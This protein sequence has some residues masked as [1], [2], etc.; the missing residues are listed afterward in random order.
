MLFEL[1]VATLS[2][3]ITFNMYVDLTHS[4]SEFFFELDTNCHPKI[5]N[6]HF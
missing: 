2:C 4:L 1:N 3:E 6:V 5:Q